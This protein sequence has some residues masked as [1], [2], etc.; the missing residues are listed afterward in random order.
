MELG[1]GRKK[2]RQYATK[3]PK[4]QIIAI[5]ETNCVWMIGNNKTGVST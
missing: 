2:E 5:E 4:F 1:P 3:I